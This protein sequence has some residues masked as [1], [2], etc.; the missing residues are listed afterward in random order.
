MCIKRSLPFSE[1]N[2]NYKYLKRKGSGTYLDLK[3][4]K[5]SGEFRKLHDENIRDLCRSPSIVRIVTYTICMI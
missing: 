5:L 4:I 1:K 3:R 2:I